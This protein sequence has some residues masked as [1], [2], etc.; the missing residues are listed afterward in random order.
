MKPS[1]LSGRFAIAGA[2]ALGGVLL[3]SCARNDGV[4]PT[5]QAQQGP[6]PAPIA[7]QTTKPEH[8]DVSRLI[9]LPGDVHPWEETTLYAKVPGYLETI[10]V[11]KGDRVKAGQVIATIQAPEL[12]ADRDQAQQSYE[13]ALAAAQGSRAANARTSAEQQRARAAAEKAKADYAQTAV[14]ISRARAQVAG[15]QG[16]QQQAVEQRDQAAAALE[17]S[18]AQVGKA[19]ADLEAAQADQKLADLT[20]ERYQGIY[21]KNPMLI[22]KQDVDVVEAR[23]KAA[24]SK[25]TVAQSAVDAAQRH[26]QGAQSQVRAM[27]SQIAQAQSQVEAARE[28]VNL[29]AAQQTSSRKQVEVAAQ[30]VTIGERQ[31][32]VTQAKALETQ[33]QAGAG[34]SA[35]G[36]TASIA[37]YIRIR[38]P[39]GGVVTKRFVDRGAF[40]QTAAASQNAAPIATVANLEEVRLYLNVPETQAQFVQIGTPV[41]ITTTAAPDQAIKG[42]V[43]RTATALDPKSRTLLAEVDLPNHDGKIL[44]GT[45]ATGRIVMETHRDVVSVPSDAIGVEKTGKFVFVVQNGKAKRVP[46]TT[47]FNDGAYTEVSNGL[48]GGEQV[49]VTGRDA[50]TPNAPLATTQWFPLLIH[51]PKKDK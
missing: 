46:V 36:R 13:S 12:R 21:D 11:D 32:K 42:R 3:V 14:T 19:K 16:A 30:D 22:A 28:Q 18:R 1:T 40:I 34:R 48:H 5:A 10:T 45:Y 25:T 15:A 38:A 41:T 31:Q 27:T 50:L 43:R 17:E 51:S 39:F 4:E 37:D 6:P 7:V 23:A 20:Y 24:R 9:S 44:A 35:L 47:G 33:F 2:T 8:R 29:T 26:V 49:V